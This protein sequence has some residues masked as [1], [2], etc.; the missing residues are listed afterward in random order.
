MSELKI[1]FGESAEKQKGIWIPDTYSNENLF[2]QL[3][4]ILCAFHID[5]DS[6]FNKL[7]TSLIIATKNGF[8]H[9]TD[10]EG[11][12]LEKLEQALDRDQY[13]KAMAV[14]PYQ[15]NGGEH[16]PILLMN[17]GFHFLW[18]NEEHGLSITLSDNGAFG[19]TYLR[20]VTQL[21]ENF[22]E[23]IKAN[24]FAYPNDLETYMSKSYYPKLAPQGLKIEAFN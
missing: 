14:C 2:I 10:Q 8:L 11:V 21:D 23:Y 22:N 7:K 17:N 19:S 24:F 1:E 3:D 15:N 4:E 9:F 18:R 20:E 16:Q 5:A 13:F 6:N 12:G